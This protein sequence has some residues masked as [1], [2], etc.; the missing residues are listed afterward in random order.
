MGFGERLRKLRERAGLSQSGLAGRASL[1]LRSVQNWEQGHRT[2]RMDALLSLARG[3][4]APVEALLSD[5]A[6]AAPAAE[7]ATAPGPRAKGRRGGG[8]KKKE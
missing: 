4:G 2:P 7:E 1:P 6:S 3:L 5:G 8:G